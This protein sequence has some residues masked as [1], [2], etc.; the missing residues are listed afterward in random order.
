[1]SKKAPFWATYFLPFFAVFAN[2][3]M[4]IH[5]LFEVGVTIDNEVQGHYVTRPNVTRPNV[6]RPNVTRPNVTRPNVTFTISDPMS[7]SQMS[8]MPNV[9]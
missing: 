6:T 9:A 1:V 5:K 7:P 4:H 3:L 8:P 2:H